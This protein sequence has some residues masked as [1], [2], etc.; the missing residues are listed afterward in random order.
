MQEVCEDFESLD[1]KERM[2]FG[3]VVVDVMMGRDE[4][5]SKRVAIDEAERRE[6]AQFYKM[7][8]YWPSRE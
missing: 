5:R 8:S 4:V 2:V 6:E 3:V 1:E 7:K